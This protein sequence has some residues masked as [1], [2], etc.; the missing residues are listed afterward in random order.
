MSDPGQMTDQDWQK[1]LSPQ[2]YDVT[3]RRGTEPPFSGEY[4]D[5]KE[6]GIYKCVCCG[7]ELF[8]S[9]TK[10][11]SGTGWPSFFDVMDPAKVKLSEDVSLGVPRI[12]VSRSNCDAHLGHVFPD[13][14][15]P[16]GKRYCINSVALD[17]DRGK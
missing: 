7:I 3:R 14:P 12:E 13:G 16:T 4:C 9:D 10:F 15:A 5:C 8:K 11:D 2:Q 1:A 17:L 6:P